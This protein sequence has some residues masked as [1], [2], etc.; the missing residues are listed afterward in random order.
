VIDAGGDEGLDAGA[1]ARGLNAMID[2]LWL[3]ILLDTKACDR[4]EALRVCRAYLAQ[5]FPRE[6]GR[7]SS[8]A[9]AA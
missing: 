8:V 9:S 3:S 5:L 7:Q 1:I 4:K 6:F 2:G